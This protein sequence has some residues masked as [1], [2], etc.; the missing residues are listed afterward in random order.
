MTKETVLGSG[1]CVYVF[2]Y[3]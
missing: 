3:V 2:K 1:D